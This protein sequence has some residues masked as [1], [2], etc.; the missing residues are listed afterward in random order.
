MKVEVETYSGYRADERPC[1]FVI[2]GVAR[3]IL[4]VE[5]RWYSPGDDWFRIRADDGNL[6]V[7]RHSREEDSWTVDAFRAL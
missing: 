1:R 4:T 6:Y 5:D 7:L 3:D 2:G